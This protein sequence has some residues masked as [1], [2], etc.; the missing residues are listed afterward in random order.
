MSSKS[1]YLQINGTYYKETGT[2]SKNPISDDDFKKMM[3]S[4]PEE[5]RRLLALEKFKRDRGLQPV[6]DLDEIQNLMNGGSFLENRRDRLKS[7]GQGAKKN[8]VSYLASGAKALGMDGAKESLQAKR[9]EIERNTPNAGWGMAGEMIGDPINALPAGIFFKGGKAA[10]RVA[11]SAGAGMALGATT[12]A[13]RDYGNETIDAQGMAIN[14]AVS[15]VLWGG[16]NAMFAS[17]VAQKVWDKLADP[18]KNRFAHLKKN[19]NDINANDGKMVEEMMNN[20]EAFGL[21][22]EDAST[23]RATFNANQ[24]PDG[25]WGV[26]ER[27]EI[28]PNAGTNYQPNWNYGRA[29]FPP[30]PVDGTPPFPDGGAGQIGWNG[31]STNQLGYNGAITAG[32]DGWAQPLGQRAQGAIDANGGRWGMEQVTLGQQGTPVVVVPKAM[33]TPREAL[34]LITKGARPVKEIP[35][36]IQDPNSQ[37]NMYHYSDEARDVLTTGNPSKT[38]GAETLRN[39][40]PKT[41][42]YGRGQAPENAVGIGHAGQYVHEVDMSKYN[43]FDSSNPEHSSRM[44]DAILAKKKEALA[45]DKNLTDATRRFYE[46]NLDSYNPADARTL[47]EQVMKEQGFQG[48]IDRA[49]GYS[50]LFESATPQRVAKLDGSSLAAGAEFDGRVTMASEALPSTSLPAGQTI[51]KM[52]ME[53]Q[54]EYHKA[55]QKMTTDE[56]GFELALK[57]VG[58]E[59]VDSIGT[60]KLSPSSYE[61]HVGAGQQ[62]GARVPTVPDEHGFD[63]I[64]DYDIERL[65]L[66]GMI[67]AFLQ[68]Q[69]A[70]TFRHLAPARSLDEVNS[71]SYNLGRPISPDEM[72]ELSA[73]FSKT[74]GDDSW[75]IALTTSKDGIDVLGVGGLK[76]QEFQSVLEAAKEFFG[77]LKPKSMTEGY[78]TLA[79]KGYIEGVKDDGQFKEQFRLLATKLRGSQGHRD[80]RGAKGAKLQWSSDDNYLETLFA[81]RDEIRR[82]TDEF[83]RANTSRVEPKKPNTQPQD[84]VKGKEAPQNNPKTTSPPEKTTLERRADVRNI[85]PEKVSKEIEKAIKVGQGLDKAKT[86]FDIAWH[87]E[88]YEAMF[89]VNSHR[90]ITMDVSKK[91]ELVAEKEAALKVLGARVEAL[92]AKALEANTSGSKKAG[93]LTRVAS[94]TLDDGHGTIDLSKLEKGQMTAH[95]DQV[96]FKVGDEL[97]NSVTNRPIGYED[98]PFY[99]QIEAMQRHIDIEGGSKMRKG[100]IEGAAAQNLFAGATGAG[101]G[102]TQGETTEERL[103]N[104]ALGAAGGVAAGGFL[105]KLGGKTSTIDASPSAIRRVQAEAKKRAAEKGMPQA[106]AMADNS[107]VRFKETSGATPIAEGGGAKVNR[108]PAARDRGVPLFSA[109]GGSIYGVEQDENG[110]YTFNPEKALMGMALGAGAVKMLGGTS[111]ATKLFSSKGKAVEYARNFIQKNVS[112]EW[113]AVLDDLR[114]SFTNTLSDAYMKRRELVTRHASGMSHKLQNMHKMLHSLDPQSRIAVHKAL[115]GEGE[116]PEAL[117]P[118]VQKIRKDIDALSNELVDLGVLDKKALEE[119]EGFYL[120]RSYEKHLRTALK[121][122]FGQ[123]FEQ[124]AILNRGRVDRLTKAELNAAM[125]SGEI[126]EEMLSKP[127]RE[128]GV[129]VKELANGKVEVKRDWTPAEREAMGEITDAS[130]TVPETLLRMHRMAENAKFLREVSK[131]TD[132]ASGAI[133]LTPERISEL[134]I[135]GSV[136]EVLR[137]A[138]YAKMPNS[139]KL[140]ALAGQWVRKDAASDITRMGD[141]L[142]G[143]FR[144]S[145]SPLANLWKSYLKHWKLGKTVGNAPTHLNNILSSTFLMHLTGMS[146]AEVT[147]S[148]GRAIK[149]ISQGRRFDDLAIKKATGKISPNELKELEELGDAVNYY[150]EA[151]ELGLFGRSQLGDSL[152]GDVGVSGTST[153]AKVMNKASEYYQLEDSVA[154]LAMYKT[155]R[156]K[157]KMGAEESLSAVSAIIP[158]YTKPIPR[159]WKALRDFGVSP[160]I[161]WTYYTMPNVIRA[162]NTRQGAVQAAKVIAALGAIEYAT[163][164][165]S[166]IDNV[167][168]VDGQKPDSYKRRELG[169][170]KSGDEISN[171]K[172]NRWIPYFELLEPVNFVK[173][174]F[175]GVGTN[176]AV[177]GGQA[178][179]GG[180]KQTHKLYNGMPIT[181]PNKTTG[182][183]AYDIVKHIGS[184]YAP[185]PQQIWHGVELAESMAREKQNRKNTRAHVPRTTTQEVLRFLG[186]NSKTYSRSGLAAER[187]AEE[188]KKR[189]NVPTF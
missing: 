161:S 43:M 82:A 8:I 144:G 71:L 123:N 155:L 150:K 183:Q 88:Q 166:P 61:G 124:G 122:V 132:D 99:P 136:D 121:D 105:R 152:M 189:R 36:K 138:G 81:K 62:T 86:K 158:D 59:Q 180:G 164:G 137:R 143:T 80:F 39:G 167:W 142:Y 56:H 4:A 30:V 24:K 17:P 54:H 112:S 127:L 117:K 14:A 28:N 27:T 15:G 111:G 133:V 10:H 34:E 45:N 64:A 184:S 140:G 96:W 165:I 76:G 91:A 29:E 110:N 57:D 21:S 49:R 171:I 97:Y 13:A 120:H 51:S 148:M 79:D 66:S 70:V 20:P 94:E 42:F 186:L 106:K 31:K 135:E 185:V 98:L 69:D 50:Y 5:D 100:F 187:A 93:R 95:D 182:Q 48:E 179:L 18:I 115:V 72:K 119:W 181:R 114:S 11:K 55:I 168:G 92:Q 109:G 90:V 60:S 74:L 147:T 87:L 160:F 163:T 38:G 188:S 151:Q 108:T 33:E 47:K 23:V 1:P 107:P 19:P 103:R 176:L 178:L 77:K 68:D 7:M 118:L 177:E 116:A 32:A 149:I 6:E 174:Q 75:K 134:G 156:E 146:A 63:A 126:T 131:M 89:G 125:E 22:P 52:S 157:Y 101:V 25:T 3:S 16:M 113:A 139:T 65:K 154:R 153:Y 9:R 67:K 44:A 170:H 35:V 145:D 162:L 58:F 130:Y 85:P 129:R 102:S 84:V 53:K 141:E 172:V 26:G 159:G 104:A 83:I 173:S 40:E 169:V 175:A 2:P 78:N 37:F 41:F 73:I 12:S 128:G 46:Q